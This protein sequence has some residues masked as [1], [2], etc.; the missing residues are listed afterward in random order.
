MV[1]I[2]FA[3]HAFLCACAGNLRGKPVCKYEAD[4]CLKSNR[5][6]RDYFD[7]LGVKPVSGPSGKGRTRTHLRLAWHMCGVSVATGNVNLV[8]V[9][10]VASIIVLIVGMLGARWDLWTR[11]A[12]NRP[13]PAAC[14]PDEGRQRRGT[15]W[16]ARTQGGG[17]W[18]DRGAA[19][20]RWVERGTGSSSGQRRD[21]E[22]R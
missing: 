18:V 14:P 21:T 22:Y 16:A 20:S 13:R 6:V 2:K 7:S 1:Y 15:E 12:R 17:G 9:W 11:D 19:S 8:I 3:C 10:R 4:V 5:E